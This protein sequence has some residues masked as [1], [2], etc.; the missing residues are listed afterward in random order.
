MNTIIQLS[1]QKKMLILQ[2][3]EKRRTFSSLG[4]VGWKFQ[5]TIYLWKTV[6]EKVVLDTCTDLHYVVILSEWSL[7]YVTIMKLAS[8]LTCAWHNWPLLIEVNFSNSKQPIDGFSKL[9]CL[10]VSICFQLSD[11]TKNSNFFMIWCPTFAF[12]G[13]KWHCFFKLFST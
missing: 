1:D 6:L 10:L 11:Y 8:E 3:C 4:L 7:K 2:N 12:Y 5:Q 9:L 13:R